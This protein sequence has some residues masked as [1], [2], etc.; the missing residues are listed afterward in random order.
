MLSQASKWRRL[1]IASMLLCIGS[2]IRG[3]EVRGT[4]VVDYHGLFQVDASARE[5]RIS[6]ALLPDEGQ[7]LI[8]RARQTESIEIIGNRMHPAFITI[9]Q[10]DTIQ[11][12]NRDP[13]FHEIFSLSPGKPVSVQLGK[14]GSGGPSKAAFTLHEMGTTHFFCRI[15]NKSYA[16]VD[17]VQTPYLKMVSPGQNF[18]FGGL[19]AGKWTLRLASPA[20]ET[21]WVPVTALTSPPP[22]KLTLP[23][24]VGGTGKEGASTRSGAELLYQN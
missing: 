20:A 10:G 18:H 4:V 22:L 13:V 19:P 5:H 2:D 1:A 15:H 14:S 9:T 6:V 8:R 16:R 23:S 17:V 12:I 11:F 3:A 21:Q 24:R 7:P